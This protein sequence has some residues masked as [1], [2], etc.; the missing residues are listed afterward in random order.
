MQLAMLLK[1]RVSLEF[2]RQNNTMGAR[3]TIQI[4]AIY[5]VRDAYRYT[6]FGSNDIISSPW[7]SKSQSL[8]YFQVTGKY[9]RLQYFKE[10]I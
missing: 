1:F 2:K 10:T 9:Q 8:F 7:G 3:I 6:V 4:S 5:T